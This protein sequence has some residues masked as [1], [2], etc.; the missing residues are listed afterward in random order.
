MLTLLSA[1]L[2]SSS[3]SEELPDWTSRLAR[4]TAS[5]T[6]RENSPSLRRQPFTSET[7]NGALCSPYLQ[8]QPL[9]MMDDS[10]SRN[11]S[12]SPAGNL[13]RVHPNRHFLRKAQIF[14]AHRALLAGLLE[15]GVLQSDPVHTQTSDKYKMQSWE[16]SHHPGNPVKIL[17]KHLMS[18]TKQKGANCSSEI[19]HVST[20]ACNGQTCE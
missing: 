11:V 7:E 10:A 12:D 13:S 3:S 20:V 18:H 5:W 4:S 15:D 2:P 17:Q 9:K 8:R 6:R 14:V 16:I 19:C 1:P